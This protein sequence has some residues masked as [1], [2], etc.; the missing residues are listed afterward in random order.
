MKKLA[1]SFAAVAALALPSLATAQATAGAT[2]NYVGTVLTAGQKNLDLGSFLPGADVT[3]A[4][5][6][7]AAVGVQFNARSTVSITMAENGKLTQK[8]VLADGNDGAAGFFTPVYTC[9]VVD[10]S[11]SAPGATVVVA[12]QACING[13]I[14]PFDLPLANTGRQTQ[15]WVRVG[16]AVAPA[17]TAEQPAGSYQGTMQVTIKRQGT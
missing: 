6:A 17:L 3:I 14:T 10:G 11:T 1:L 9:D 13:G 12:N 8:N 16:A 7:G 5:S 4:P 2:I 15:R